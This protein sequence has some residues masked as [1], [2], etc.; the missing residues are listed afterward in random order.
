MGCTGAAQQTPSTGKSHMAISVTS[1][2]KVLSLKRGWCGDP[3]AQPTVVDASP[4][5]WAGN[6]NTVGH[7]ASAGQPRSLQP[8]GTALLLA[9]ASVNYWDIAQGTRGPVTLAACPPR[10]HLLDLPKASIHIRGPSPTPVSHLDASSAHAGSTR[11]RLRRPAG[12]ARCRRCPARGCPARGGGARRCRMRAPR[13]RDPCSSGGPAVL[14]GA[15]CM[16]ASQDNLWGEGDEDPVSARPGGSHGPRGAHAGPFAQT[17]LLRD[18]E[19]G[20]LAQSQTLRD[21]E[22]HLNDLKKENFSLKLRIYF[23]E[24]RVQQK[25][26]GSRDD[27]YRRNIE[28][29][30]EVES[31]KRELQEKQQAL[32]N[33][34]RPGWH[35]MRPSRPQ[36]WPGPRQSGARNWQGS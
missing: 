14:P 18:L 1:W 20:P 28:L 8:P 16:A 15:S 21:F 7:A 30:V 19:M 27:V 5:V 13:G 24:E 25:G 23:L 4:A 33:K 32:D 35:G 36:R 34:W 3:M 22:Q 17:C 12:S 10:K 11:Q 29:K 31:L 9:L 6:A 26:E 2:G